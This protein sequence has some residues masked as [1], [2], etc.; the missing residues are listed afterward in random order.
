MLH[1]EDLLQM[2]ADHTEAEIRAMLCKWLDCAEP[3]TTPPTASGPKPAAVMEGSVEN[4]GFY[5][6]VNLNGQPIRMHLDTGAFEMLLTKEIADALNLPN[7]GPLQIAGVTGSSEAY[8]SHVTVVLD[9][10][11]VP[12]VHCVVDPSY[13]GTPLFGFRFFIDHQYTVAVNPVAQTVTLY[14][15]S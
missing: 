5:F 11:D 13:T 12:D 9:N 8:Q 14:S 15:A 3:P 4:D 1:K 6:R 7:D 2:I 10:L